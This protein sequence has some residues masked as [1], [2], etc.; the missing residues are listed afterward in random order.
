METNKKKVELLAP[1]GNFDGFIGAVNGGADAVYLSGNRFGAR[2]YA[3]N[4]TQEE[5][6]QALFLAKLFSVKVYL[7]VNTLFKNTELK[8]LYDYLVPFYKLGLTGVIVQD[9]GVFEFIR[10]NFPGLE[11]H[12]STQMAVTGVEG[13]KY[14][15]KMGAKRIVPARELTLKEIKA[16]KEAG[17]ETECFIHGAMCYCVSG[18]CLFSSLIGGR[19]GNR[20]RC[21]Q[22]C[23]LPY[24]ANGKEGYYLSLKDMCTLEDLP[25][26]IDAG[27]DSFKIEGRMKHPA[28]AA[29][30]T[31]IYRKYIDLY[32]EHPTKEYKVDKKDLEELKSLYIRSSLQNGYYS[33][34]RGKDMITLHNPSYSGTDDA[35]VAQ[36]T[37]D[38]IRK[39]PGCPIEMKAEFEV[40]KPCT[41][42][43]SLHTKD[44]SFFVSVEGNVVEKAIKAPLSEQDIKERLSK[45]GDYPFDVKNIDVS[46]HGE[47]FLP[48]K[49]IN[50]LRRNALDSLISKI[51][52]DL[53]KDR[54]EAIMQHFAD[55]KDHRD[56][57][58]TIQNNNI[59]NKNNQTI[60]EF[61]AFAETYEQWK[62]ILN[63]EYISR[64][65]LPLSFLADDNFLQ[66]KN[67]CTKTDKTVYFRLPAICRNDSINQI[68][69]W[70]Q[71]YREFGI[72][73]GVYV[74]Q[75]DS[76][77]HIKERYPE[78]ECIGDINLYVM[79]DEAKLFFESR[80]NA[81]TIPVEL[82]K[83]ELKHMDL[84]NGEMLLYGRIPLMHTANCIFLTVGNCQK[85]KKDAFGYLS[86]KTNAIFP[87]QGH[88]KETI[89]Y[90]TIYNSVPTSLHKHKTVLERLNCKA[91]QLRFTTEDAAAT[92]KVLELYR[93]IAQG[94]NVNEVP[95]AYT[96]GHFLRGI[97]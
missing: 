31:S 37:E 25:A 55:D 46:V 40:S 44:T 73:T 30:V 21:A 54:S 22:P 61:V 10:R 12:V 88:C 19:S 52:A 50:A 67:A 28:Y 58:I 51:K 65:V 18:Q 49:A 74:N 23:R 64:V 2:A 94:H 87:Y 69:T 92:R 20:G 8:E 79:N 36:I 43:V 68:D 75:I 26:L 72:K 34:L 84:A 62:E 93:N 96:N 70:M 90:N 57:N 39:I 59:D 27:I 85:D 3:D 97:Q 63:E 60:A 47:I 7:T 16:F 89:C 33:K 81:F 41:L 78:T 14:L 6:E 11:L 38:M 83:E 13:A 4:F 15:L 29:R 42:K 17:I 80:L 66:I 35:L 77:A 48:V 53:Q 32:L 95:F 91:Y 1:A 76:M 45:T 5:L 86:D 71:T 56:H 9:L 82:N 24:K